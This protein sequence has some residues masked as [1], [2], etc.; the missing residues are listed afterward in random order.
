MI[1]NIRRAQPTEQR[2]AVASKIGAFVCVTALVA[3]ANLHYPTTFDESTL[4]QASGVVTTTQ[5][6]APVSAT[7]PKEAKP[8][9][10]PSEYD[11]RGAE[12]SEPVA[13][14]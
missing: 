4:L 12:P 9:Y 8:Y 5:A 6:A 10:M 7:A 11:L 3:A 14:F 2:F 13:T 1:D